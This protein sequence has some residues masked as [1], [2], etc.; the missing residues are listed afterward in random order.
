MYELRFRGNCLKGSLW[1]HDKKG[2]PVCNETRLRTDIRIRWCFVISSWC[3]DGIMIIFYTLTFEK[4]KLFDY[5][6]LF[7]DLISLQ[8]LT[9]RFS[10]QKSGEGWRQWRDAAH[11]QIN[12]RKRYYN[13]TGNLPH[14]VTLARQVGCIHDNMELRNTPQLPGRITFYLPTFLEAMYQ[15]ILSPIFS[16]ILSW[17]KL[18]NQGSTSCN[19]WWVLPWW[20]SHCSSGNV[21]MMH[22]NGVCDELECT[23]H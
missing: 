7:Y 12:V 4:T 10:F 5:I 3:W 20:L 1:R 22:K 2:Y 17:N 6:K 14:L 8:N 15:P 18:N 16:V 19:C 21:S 13:E 23:A 9:G 11:F